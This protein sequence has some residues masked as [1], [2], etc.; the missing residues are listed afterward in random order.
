MEEHT[1]NHFG[2][3][4]CS[5]SSVKTV[6]YP[7]TCGKRISYPLHHTTLEDYFISAAFTIDMINLIFCEIFVA[8]GLQSELSP[9]KLMFVYFEK[10]NAY[11]EKKVNSLVD[12]NCCRKSGKTFYSSAFSSLQKYKKERNVFKDASQ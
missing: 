6:F 11:D 10:L 5:R 4:K 9:L 12:L 3:S 1:G 7:G 8:L 2:I